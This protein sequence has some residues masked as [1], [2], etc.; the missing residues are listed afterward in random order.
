MHTR[1]SP[2]DPLYP[3]ILRDVVPD[4]S[5]YALGN[6]DLLG[7][8]AVGIC[9]SRDASPEAQGYAQRFGEEA[10][11]NGLVVVSGYARGVDREAHKGVLKAGGSTV[12]V[13]AEGINSFR[14]LKE[15]RPLA[16]LSRNLLVLSMFG[17]DS[18]WAV[19]RA[20]ERNKLIVGLSVALFVVEARETGGTI[21][22]AM[23]CVR[24]NKPL[25]AIAYSKGGAKREGNRKLLQ[26]SAIPLRRRRDLRTA[27]EAAATKSAERITQLALNLS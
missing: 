11:N 8:R 12:A 13:L 26:A 9:G 2:S 18:M 10:A 22:A 24:Q 15:L 27:M 4:T 17:P 23:E 7:Q 14:L 20:M 25:W 21:N 19:W 1:V 16:D 6:L 5:L 3:A